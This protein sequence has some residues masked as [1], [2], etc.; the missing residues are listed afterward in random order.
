MVVL[1][2]LS[3]GTVDDHLLVRL[4][5]TAHHS[6]GVVGRA[7]EDLDPAEGLGAAPRWRPLLVDII[8]DHHRC[9]SVA[10]NRLAHVCRG[11]CAGPPPVLLLPRRLAGWVGTGRGRGWGREEAGPAL[12]GRSLGSGGVSGRLRD[13]HRLPTGYLGS[14]PALRGGRI[15]LL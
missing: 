13:P 10:D 14:C 15:L 12:R 8:I 1:Q 7:V 3:N 11:S 4:H 6:E 2:P 9:P 5:L